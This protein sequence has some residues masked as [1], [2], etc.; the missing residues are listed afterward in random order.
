SALLA[1]LWGT[2]TVAPLCGAGHLYLYQYHGRNTFARGHHYRLSECR[3][4]VAHVHENAARIREAVTHYPIARPCLVLGREGPAFAIDC[5]SPYCFTVVIGPI[6]SRA[7]VLLSPPSLSVYRRATIHSRD[8]DEHARYR[9]ACI[10]RNVT[11]RRV[12]AL[13]SALVGA[14][15]AMR[16][17]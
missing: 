8:G 3:T 13:R 17:R 10:C 1:S 12:G 7:T 16:E 2:T 15:G 11:R 5:C 6:L 9:Q 4:A 14:R